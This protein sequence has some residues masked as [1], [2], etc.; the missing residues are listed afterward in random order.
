MLL[1]QSDHISRLQK[2]HLPQAIGNG[3]TTRSPTFTRCTSGPVGTAAA[4]LLKG[5]NEQEIREDL[6]RL[7]SVMEAGEI[8]RIAGQSS[9][10]GR[11]K[12][13]P[14]GGSSRESRLWGRL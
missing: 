13:E 5:V 8:P 1:S 11:D 9:G 4:H 14:G 7:K 12:E 10:R 3:I 6:R 2:K